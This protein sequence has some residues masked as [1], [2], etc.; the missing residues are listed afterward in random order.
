MDRLRASYSCGS[1]LNGSF[2]ASALRAACLDVRVS[3]SSIVIPRIDLR[4]DVFSLTAT[5][6]KLVEDAFELRISE[7]SSSEV[8]QCSNDFSSCWRSA[9]PQDQK[10]R[11]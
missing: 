7:L 1:L 5:D 11:R 6:T 10:Q 2:P 3:S 8:T 4:C 9:N